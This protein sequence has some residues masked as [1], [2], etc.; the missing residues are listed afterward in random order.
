[1][2]KK[3][4]ITG[5]SGYL[6][7]HL[8]SHLLENQC[9]DPSSGTELDIIAVYGSLES[10]ANAKFESNRN[11]LMAKVSLDLTDSDN[12]SNF[13]AKERPDVLV[14][15]AAMS[16]PAACAKDPE[17]AMA[18]NCPKTLVQACKKIGTFI[19]F[20]S[21][22]HVYR[23]DRN[24]NDPY[25]IE[26]DSTSP[27]NV[28]GESKLA[29]ERLLQLKIPERSVS[30]RSSI[31]LGPPTKNVCRKQT[32][33]QFV[34]SRLANKQ[35]TEYFSDEWRNVVFVKDICKIISWFIEQNVIKEV[36]GIYNMG[37]NNRV[38]RDELAREVARIAF[39]QLSKTCIESIVKPVI[40][41]SMPLPSG[42]KEAQVSKSPPDI[43]MDSSKLLFLCKIQFVSLDEMI[44]SSNGTN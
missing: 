39:P 38:S 36:C 1:M 18:I 17:K 32:F 26:T 4:V 37:G 16:S 2:R 30:L 11:N 3:V 9:E 20:L 6:G 25:Y 24:E 5:S 22:D 15:L 31:I 41:A 29:F 27:I 33:L 34:Y 28:Y 19:I 21:T 7:Q 10:F 14:H 8:L 35:A 43:A 40:K 12:I 42:I 23:G 13:I 44:F